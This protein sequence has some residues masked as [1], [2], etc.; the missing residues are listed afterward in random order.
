MKY[1]RDTL[2]RL[3]FIRS[4]SEAA[5]KR[6]LQIRE[7][8]YKEK[9]PK[10][11]ITISVP[12]VL[13][14]LTTDHRLSVVIFMEKL[15]DKCRKN[16]KI[17]INFSQTHRMIADGAILLFA[18][19]KRI[20]ELKP[21]L[22]LRCIRSRDTKVNE[23]LE[24]IGLFKF[25]HYKYISQVKFEDVIHWHVSEG[26]STVGAKYEDVL[27]SYDDILS[28]KLQGSFYDGITEAMTNSKKHAYTGIRNDGFKAQKVNPKW[29]MFSQK[30]DG[31]L[32][33]VFCD[34]GVGI[35]ATLPFKKPLIYAYIKNNFGTVTDSLCI[36][37][38]LKYSVSRTHKDERGKGLKD[39]AEWIKC[40]EGGTFNIFSNRGLYRYV[41]NKGFSHNYKSNILGTIITWRVPISDSL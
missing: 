3:Q 27:G 18:E 39:I 29:W 4:I 21:N 38:A 9:A 36:V 16:R 11:T 6:T 8:K 13:D 32:T 14:L 22:V 26:M 24:Q 10:T 25:L 34:L 31:Y 1:Q 17:I 28:E 40:V 5:R 2:S 20:Q 37:E 12:E 33:V 19:L 23:A 35:P 15:R 7:E 41:N 30:K